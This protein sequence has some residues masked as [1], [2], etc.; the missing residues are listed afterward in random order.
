[1]K[2]WA[3]SVILFFASMRLH[4]LEAEPRVKLGNLVSE[5]GGWEGEIFSRNLGRAETH[6]ALYL[7]P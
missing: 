4:D 5:P 3:F 1:M 2:T 6:A 7:P